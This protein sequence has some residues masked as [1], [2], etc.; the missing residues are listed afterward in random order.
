MVHELITAYELDTA[1]EVVKPRVATASELRRFHSASYIAYLQ[2]FDHTNPD[3]SVEISESDDE[4]DNSDSS[5]DNDDDC[6]DDTFDDDRQ[7][8]QDFGLGY[9]CPPLRN[10]WPLATTVAGATVT[11]AVECMRGA[12]VVINWCG[13]W[14][15]AQPH[16]AEGF[17]YVNDIGCAIRKLRERF[18]RVLY[19]D[20]DVHHGNGV[21]AGFA[22]SRSVFTL[23]FHQY[24]AGFYPGSGGV[25]SMGQ[26]GPAAGYMCNFPYKGYVGGALFRRYFEK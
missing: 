23:S 3:A 1:F 11:A 20:L 21:E 7:R 6:H 9:D 25:E 8:Q 14:H 12:R 4:D 19:V 26:G 10:L 5:E 18:E 2:S 22:R 13:G 17:C 15:H 16:A 24:E